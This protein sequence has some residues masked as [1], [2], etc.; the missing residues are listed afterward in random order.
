MQKHAQDLSLLNQFNANN[1]VQNVINT[2]PAATAWLPLRAKHQNMV[3]LI[4]KETAQV[5][6]IVDLRPWD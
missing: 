4:N 3:V 6:A 5:I 1:D 2:Y